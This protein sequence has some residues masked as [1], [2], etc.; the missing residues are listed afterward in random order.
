MYAM[1]VV[2]GCWNIS[3]GCGPCQTCAHGISVE[4]G[5]YILGILGTHNGNGQVQVLHVPYSLFVRSLVC[6][7]SLSTFNVCCWLATHKWCANPKP[8][9][10]RGEFWGHNN[11]SQ[12]YCFKRSLIKRLHVAIFPIPL[13]I[14]LKWCVVFLSSLQLSNELFLVLNWFIC[15]RRSLLPFTDNHFTSNAS[16]W[17]SHS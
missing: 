6:V 8:L 9:Y 13:F 3:V 4:R 1:C 7:T 11:R 12:S 14:S 5:R 10:I 16:W 2:D 15:Y 17:S